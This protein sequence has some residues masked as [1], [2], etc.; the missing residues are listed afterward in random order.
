[1]IY[2]VAC[3]HVPAIL[4]AVCSESSGFAIFVRALKIALLMFVV[5]LSI[6]HVLSMLIRQAWCKHVVLN[7]LFVNNNNNNN[8]VYF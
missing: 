6:V 8:I 3:W 2:F 5:Y 1:M 7:C 4:V